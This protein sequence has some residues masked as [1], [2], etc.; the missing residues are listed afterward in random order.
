MLHLL[1]RL[2]PDGAIQA[3]RFAVQHRVPV[4]TGDKVGVF[5]R[6]AESLRERDL[7]ITELEEQVR[8]L[9][10]RYR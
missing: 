2:H 3:N 8:L 1:F 4:N 10:A 5:F 9:K 6:F 7:R